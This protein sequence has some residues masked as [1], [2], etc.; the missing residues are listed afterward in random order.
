MI[1]R[2]TGEVCP[3]FHVLGNPQV[4]T[5]L[6]DGKRPALFD[7]GMSFL[8]DLYVDELRRVPVRDDAAVVGR[9]A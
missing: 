2:R 5:Y 3:G 1:F 6:L 4:P 7:S 9:A 8:G